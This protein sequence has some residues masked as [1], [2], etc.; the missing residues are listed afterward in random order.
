MSLLKKH[1][2]ECSKMFDQTQTD[3]HN[4]QHPSL[5]LNHLLPAREMGLFEHTEGNTGQKVKVKETLDKSQASE[6]AKNEIHRLEEYT[7]NNE[8]KLSP[9]NIKKIDKR[10]THLKEQITTN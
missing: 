8:N 4:P 10:I 3:T 2:S 9:E 5:L 6:K 7:K 1:N